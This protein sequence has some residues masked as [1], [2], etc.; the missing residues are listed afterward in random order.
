MYKGI[1]WKENN[2]KYTQLF[3]FF[4]NLKGSQNIGNIL[5]FIKNPIESNKELNFN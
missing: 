5:N 2:Q 3:I 1:F 4:F